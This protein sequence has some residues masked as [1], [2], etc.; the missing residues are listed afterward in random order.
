MLNHLLTD[1]LATVGGEVVHEYGIGAGK[2]HQL[3]RDLV[4]LKVPRPLLSLRLLS[5]ACPHI[6]VDDVRAVDGIT[7]FNE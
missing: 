6:R 1:F 4:A 5:H 2:L 7:G 3:W